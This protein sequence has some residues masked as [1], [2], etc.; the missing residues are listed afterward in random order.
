MLNWIEWDADEV[1]DDVSPYVVDTLGDPD[2]VLVV[3]HTGFLKTGVRSAGVKRQYSGTTGSHGELPGRRLPR[4][5]HRMADLDR[6]PRMCPRPGRNRER[7]RRAGIDDTVGFEAKVP[8]AKAV[9]RQAMADRIPFRWLTA[10]AAYG[11]SKGWRSELERADIFH[12]MATVRHDT[13]VTRW[14]IDHPRTSGAGRP[15]A[16][17]RLQA[18]TAQSH[19]GDQ[20]IVNPF[21]QATPAG[22]SNYR[23]VQPEEK[24]RQPCGCPSDPPSLRLPRPSR[25]WALPSRLRQQYPKRR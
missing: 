25:L 23:A 5:C 22:S 12:V 19:E 21:S 7:C 24:R 13:F 4:L 18:P 8:I 11:F 16:Q 14:E 10:D 2:A 20:A 1:L 3:H 6:P 15:L 9:I 17:P